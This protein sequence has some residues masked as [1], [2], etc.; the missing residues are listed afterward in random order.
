M[1]K[2]FEKNIFGEAFANLMLPQFNFLDLFVFSWLEM[3][4][5]LDIL[6]IKKFSSRLLPLEY[7]NFSSLLI[8]S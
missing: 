7:Q 1:N 5:F 4:S 6:A 3:Y 2:V 8:E